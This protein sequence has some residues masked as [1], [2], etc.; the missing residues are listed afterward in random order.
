[1]IWCCDDENVMMSLRFF[2][3]EFRDVPYYVCCLSYYC[4]L[5]VCFIVY[6]AII[7]YFY[8]LASLPFSA[9]MIDFVTIYE[10]SG[11]NQ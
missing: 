11:L 2:I 7:N 3:K 5:F 1:M 8:V 9:G 4:K 10:E 6:H